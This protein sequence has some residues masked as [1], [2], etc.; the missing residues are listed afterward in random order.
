MLILILL[1]LKTL[2]TMLM[3][4]NTMLMMLPTMLMMMLLMT[5]GLYDSR[6]RQLARKAAEQVSS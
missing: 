3:M 6:L 5:G 1:I 2:P 4:L